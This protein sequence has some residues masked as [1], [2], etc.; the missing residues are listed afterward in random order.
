MIRLISN[1]DTLRQRSPIHNSFS[2]IRDAG[3]INTLSFPTS[4]A[5]VMFLTDRPHTV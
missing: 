1:R 5:C 4:C 2:E 3:I